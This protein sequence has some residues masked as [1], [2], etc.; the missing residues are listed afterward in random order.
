MLDKVINNV[1]CILSSDGYSKP[2]YECDTPLSGKENRRARRKYELRKK[3][4]RL[5]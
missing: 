4:G 3:K 5:C 1:E 2:L